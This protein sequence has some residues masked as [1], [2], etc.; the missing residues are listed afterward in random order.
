[1][2]LQSMRLEQ[3]GPEWMRPMQRILK[4]ELQKKMRSEAKKL[5]QTTL[6]PMMKVGQAKPGQT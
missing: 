5:E 1:M 6:E 4:P 3:M 2:S